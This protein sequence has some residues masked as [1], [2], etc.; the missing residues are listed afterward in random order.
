MD[1]RAASQR[2]ATSARFIL[3][4]CPCHG[5]MQ[6]PA[7]VSA[8]TS[9]ASS[10]SVLCSFLQDIAQHPS[11]APS[12]GWCRACWLARSCSKGVSNTA[13]VV[14][15]P[16]ACTPALDAPRCTRCRLPVVGSPRKS[17]CRAHHNT[18]FHHNAIGW[19]HVLRWAID[20]SCGVSECTPLLDSPRCTPCRVASGGR[21]QEI[22]RRRRSVV[23]TS[24][25][26]RKV[27]AGLSF[28]SWLC[29]GQD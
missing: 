20:M 16:S 26:S 9:S 28:C 2:L 6:Q 4:L 10:A 24:R 15:R 22:E 5:R 25:H 11:P 19:I 21:P 14:R 17:I 8:W 12:P 1:S 3:P 27:H 7:L 13:P 18:L 29:P 23:A